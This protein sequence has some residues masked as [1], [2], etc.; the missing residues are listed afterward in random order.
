MTHWR[1]LW[2]W[3]GWGQEE[4]GMTEDEMAG[5]HHWLDLWKLPR[6]L[7]CTGRAGNY[8]VKSLWI[9]DEMGEFAVSFDTFLLLPPKPHV[10]QLLILQGQWGLM[11]KVLNWKSMWSPVW[12]LVNKV[13]SLV[14]LWK[15]EWERET[16]AIY[17]PHGITRY[18]WGKRLYKR[19]FF[20]I[21]NKVSTPVQAMCFNISTSLPSSQQFYL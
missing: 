1:R 15:E 8:G 13:C 5:W 14:S 17:I 12:P 18:S 16:S 9:L 21:P 2:C 4:K 3:E 11:G 7:W 6:W 20:T 19:L 10:R